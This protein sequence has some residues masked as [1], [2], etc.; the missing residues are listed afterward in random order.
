[1][2]L[3]KSELK[4]YLN[5][6]KITIPDFLFKE[7]LKQFGNPVMD[8]EGRVMEYSEQDMYEQIRKVVQLYQEGGVSGKLQ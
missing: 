8:D 3:K 6:R 5:S 1:M 2:K 7:L 4:T